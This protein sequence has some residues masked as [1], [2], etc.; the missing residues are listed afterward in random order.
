MTYPGKRYYEGQVVIDQVD[1]LA[2][3][4]AKAIFGV[5]H[6]NVQPYSGSPANLAIYLA[7]VK[8]GDTIMGMAVPM[9]GHL[10]HG[11]NVSVTGLWFNSVQYGVRKDTG[12]VDL[13]EVREIALRE[14][15]K[16]IFCGGTAIPRTIDF[17]A[18]ADI[19]AESGAP[20]NPWFLSSR[21]PVA[22][23]S[24]LASRKTVLAA[25][26][27]ALA[28]NQAMPSSYRLKA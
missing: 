5:D 26:G 10:T 19:A 21:L 20:Q 12:R 25:R 17:P 13:D 16:L 15:P 24:E 6:V 2:I 1:S 4:R 27:K 7:F 22:D 11:W 8:P 9:G 14:H 3:S 18:F 28:R 23:L